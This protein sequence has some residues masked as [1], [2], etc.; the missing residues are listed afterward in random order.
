MAGDLFSIFEPSKKKTGNPPPCPPGTVRVHRSPCFAV[1]S[2]KQPH[3]ASSSRE[4]WISDRVNREGW[5]SNNVLGLEN[6]R[7][8]ENHQNL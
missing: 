2:L 6:Q 8:S 4:S 7:I 5:L 1:D 3:L